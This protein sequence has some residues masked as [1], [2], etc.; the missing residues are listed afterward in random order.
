MEN[1]HISAL[2]NK[3]HDLEARISREAT[4]PQPD[5]ALIHALKKRKLAIK[6]ELQASAVH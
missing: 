4:R 2:R 6:D 5:D 1:S 3:H